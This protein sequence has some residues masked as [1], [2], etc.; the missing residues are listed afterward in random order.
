[1]VRFFAACNVVAWH[2]KL[3]FD[4]VALPMTTFFQPYMQLDKIPVEP[5]EVPLQMAF[6]QRARELLQSSIAGSFDVVKA[7]MRFHDVSMR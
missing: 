1:M 6:A 4:L 7:D 2:L 3:Q 5:G